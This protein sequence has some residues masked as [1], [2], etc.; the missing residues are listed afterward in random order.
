MHGFS[1]AKSRQMQKTHKPA[2]RC[3]LPV[4]IFSHRPLNPAGVQRSI[5]QSKRFSPIRLRL[6]VPPS[7]AAALRLLPPN[8]RML[9]PNHSLLPPNDGL[10]P[11]NDKKA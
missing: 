2:S 7:A 6:Q 8:D 1:E 9:P 10:L 11:A 5:E 3:R 4:C